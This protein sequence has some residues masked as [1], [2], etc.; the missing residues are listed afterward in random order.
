GKSFRDLADCQR[1]FDR[2]RLVYNHERPHDALGL[3]TPVEHYRPSPRAFPETLPAIEYG[4][5]DT[6]RK[7]DRAGFV[8]F[9]GRPV[10]IGKAFRG[11]PVALRPGRADGV[12]TIHFC[13]HEIGTID[14]GAAAPA[15]GFVDI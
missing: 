14:L 11:Q 1:E 12:F 5:G 10:R 9:R 3:A 2:W 4:S 8:S 6:V 15:C 7:V 13:A